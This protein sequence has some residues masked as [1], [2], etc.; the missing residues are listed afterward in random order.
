MGATA[1][2]LLLDATLLQKCRDEFE[3]QI[4]ERPYECP[5]PAGVTPSPLK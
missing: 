3:Q 2:N 4:T 1:L 5:I